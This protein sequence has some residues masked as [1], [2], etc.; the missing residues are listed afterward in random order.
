MD[1]GRAFAEESDRRVRFA[2]LSPPDSSM[3]RFGDRWIRGGGTREDD[4][5]ADDEADGDGAE[6]SDSGVCEREEGSGTSDGGMDL[7]WGFDVEGELF[8]ESF[9]RILGTFGGD[10][11][12]WGYGG[13]S[14]TAGRPVCGPL[15]LR[16]EEK[17]SQSW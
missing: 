13:F 8:D 12:G 6:S 10:G 15:R 11:G 3:L 17:C 2:M 5:G 1:D 14:C 16:M 9:S 4:D 7:D